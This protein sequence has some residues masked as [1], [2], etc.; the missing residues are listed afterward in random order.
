MDDSLNVRHCCQSVSIWLKVHV[1][2]RRRDAHGCNGGI[3]GRT[4][5]FL[6]CIVVSSSA[7]MMLENKCGFSIWPIYCRE[8]PTK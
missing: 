7:W 4:L 1:C 8:L 2:E 3:S 5:K 6:W